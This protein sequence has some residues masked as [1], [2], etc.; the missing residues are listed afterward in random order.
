MVHVLVVGAGYAGAQAA[1][2]AR[3]RAA[4]V[5]V[6]DPTGQHQFLTRLAGVAGG[7]S[8]SGDGWA[9]ADELLGVHIVRAEVDR[10]LTDRP[11]VR[12]ADGTLL[13][14]DAVV[15]AAGAVAS[16][17]DIPGLD[18]HA[19]PLRSVA[20]ALTIRRQ[21]VDHTGLVVIGGGATGVQVAHEAARRHH[22]LRVQVVEAGDRLL[23]GHA[24]ALGE[25]AR[26]LL[27][28]AGVRVHLGTS[29]ASVQSDRVRTDGG[30]ELR[31]I[32]LWAGG[33]RAIGN[34]LLPDAEHRDG[35]LVVT[36]TLRVPGT[37][38]V[39]AAGDIA[40]HQDAWGR[41]L[42]MSAQ[43]ADRAGTIAGRNA[44]RHAR[45]GAA[46]PAL[47]MDLGWVIGMD[48]RT[49]VAQLGPVPLALPGLDR[50]VPVLHAAI[51]AKH[52]FQV[53]GLS[54]LLTY[55]PGRHRPERSQLLRAERPA[56]R[57]VG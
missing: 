17:P 31:G 29:V 30:I 38:G 2:A 11:A 12:L 8:A 45:G 50:L 56:L 26:H 18:A 54:G 24:T 19:L 28:D 37:N 14:A 33:F 6:V 35:R 1:A 53:G 25:H 46:A 15:V 55:A 36:T 44:V 47:L 40:A 32:P 13:D 42:A 49:G 22:H 20:D 4:R 39:F 21:L 10:V 9:P 16:S 34:A 41:D 3:K 27:L 43:I 51:D 57:V 5:T 7:R 23:P 48:D 52:L